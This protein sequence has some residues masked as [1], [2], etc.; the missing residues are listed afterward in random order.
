MDEYNYII[1]EDND[2]M[3]ISM[4]G[5]LDA[6]DIEET[7]KRKYAYLFKSMQEES[8]HIRTNHC[9][10]FKEIVF[11]KK[12]VGFCAYT[13]PN[14]ISNLSL[15]AG[16]I[17]PNFRGKGLFF[18]EINRVFES[19]DTFSI[20][21]P[22]K[23]IVEILLKYGFAKK[24]SDNLIVSA[25]S[26]DIPSQSICQIHNAEKLLYTDYFYTTNI[27]DLFLDGAIYTFE[28]N[29]EKILYFSHINENIRQ[30]DNHNDY[31]DEKYFNDVLMTLEKN[32][33]E[34]STYL[35]SVLSNICPNYFIEEPVIDEK[36][37]L[38]FSSDKTIKDYEEDDKDKIILNNIKNLTKKKHSL[39]DDIDNDKDKY[40]EAYEQAALYDFIRIFEDNKNIELT[41]TIIEIDYYFKK[42]Y[43][44]DLILEKKYIINNIENEEFEEYIYSLKVNELK[45]ILKE[46]NLVLTGNKNDLI[47]RILEHVSPSEIKTGEYHVSNAGYDFIRNNSQIDFYNNILKN[48]YYY[49]FNEYLKNN[50]YSTMTETATQFLNEHLT[51]SIERRDFD[52]YNDSISSLAFIHKLNHNWNESLYYE[53][54][55][56][57][58]RLN[59]IFLDEN[60]YNYYQ[61]I[62]KNNLENLKMLLSKSNFN[63]KN[64]FVKVWNDME[65]KEFIIPFNASFNI[66]DKV[67]S[68]EDKDY[69]NDKI[70]ERYLQK[71]A[72]IHDKLD[73]SKQITLDRYLTFEKNN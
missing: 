54:K 21:E 38:F 72:V 19:G 40:I 22:S 6:I 41:D 46:N 51:L 29:E 59:P 48:F 15:A 17:L 44:K 64:E 68:G 50:N 5:M 58:I 35:E 20:Y 26:F 52:A 60:Y 57:I 53:I 42:G 43:L 9:T 18:D 62:E 31:A 25:I 10:F 23:T 24:I 30:E 34:I 55:K 2:G 32:E 8:Y 67:I 16:Y 14:K 33:S 69:M 49:E 12:V 1:R 39:N 11:K 66:L 70:R 28:D 36:V 3:I 47:K 61:P 65:I 45:D 4:D 7:L 63:L 37:N 56:F 73:N 71:D 27:Y 13:I